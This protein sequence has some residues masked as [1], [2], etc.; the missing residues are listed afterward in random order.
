MNGNELWKSDGTAAGSVMVA[1]IRPGSGSSNPSILT[2]VGGTLFFT[3]DDGLH[4]SELWKSDGTT[5]GT[6]L[7]NDINV[8]NTGS[9]PADLTNVNGTLL[10]TADDGTHGRE[11][12]K[13]DGSPAGT[14]I[15]RDIAPGNT[16]SRPSSLTSANGKLYFSATDG[17]HGQ[18]LWRSDGTVDGTVMVADINPGSADSLVGGVGL[19][20]MAVVDGS[21]YFAADDGA[22]GRE[23]WMLQPDL[24]PSVS[25]VRVNDGTAQRSRVTNLTVTFS[26]QVSFATIPG[27]AF[28]LTRASDNAVVGF[29]ATANV[30]G[31]VTVV[32]LNGFIGSATEFGSLADGR[33]TLT[34][35]ASQVS[36]GGQ[37]MTGNY[38][39]GETQGLFR[40]F[41]D[42]NGDRN[43]NGLDLG[44]FRNSFGTQVGDQN[45][46]SYLDF[47]GDGVIN[48]FDLGQFR[49]RFG[50]ML[51]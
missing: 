27:A 4:G 19:P 49:T 33:Y 28:T 17:K 20:N 9:N 13:S 51:P 24:A 11:V 45:Y 50:T 21:L 36:A 46:L 26:T 44:F 40:M 5:A 18:E 35:L 8:G 10:F 48:G 3:A 23:L 42:V 43:V 34:V 1:D 22:H 2:N 30:V 32:T 6:A 38:S 7:I 39:F 47:N 15:V 31:G 41:G 14:V 25:S 16:T 29:T 12:W 37:Q